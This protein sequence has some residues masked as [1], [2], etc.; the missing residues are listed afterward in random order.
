MPSFTEM[1]Y[2]VQGYSADPHLLPE[3][4]QAVELGINYQHKGFYG[5]AVIWHH[6]GKNMMC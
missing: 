3:E 4:M 1:Y 5:T 2:K 6:H